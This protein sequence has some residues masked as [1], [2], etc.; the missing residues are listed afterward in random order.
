MTVYNSV[1]TRADMD[2]LYV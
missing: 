1:H 2:R